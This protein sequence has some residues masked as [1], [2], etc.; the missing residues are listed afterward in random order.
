MSVSDKK[1]KVLFD[2]APF[3]IS[4]VDSEN[5]IIES[6]K[7]L[8]RILKITKEDLKEEI[9]RK[10]KYIDSAGKELLSE[11]FPSS[12]ALK[13]KKT[14]RDFEIGIIDDQERTI[15]TRVSAIPFI[16]DGDF[17]V[18][19]VRDI[20]EQKEAELALQES[21]ERYR[22]LM[23]NSGLG[24][25]YYDLSGKILMIN[26]IAVQNIGGKLS[27]YLGKNLI[28]V[29][30]IKTGQIFIER[31]KLSSKSAR[32]IQFEDRLKVHSNYKWYLSTYNRI[33]DKNGN[34]EGIQVTSADITGRKKNEIQIS[35]SQE[36][37]HKLTIH[38]EEIRESE[39]LQIAMNL[40]DDLG[41]KLTALNLNLA[42][43]KKRFGKQLP[44]IGEKI[45]EMGL[46]IQESIE[47]IREIS[48]Y[49]RPPL[50][51]DL[52][53]IPAFESLIKK[54]EK[55]SGIK[56]FFT[57][58]SDELKGNNKISV[59]LYRV[60]QESLTNIARHSGASN[61][62]VTLKTLK[63]NTELIISDDG[64]GIKTREIN[65]GKSLGIAGIKER[66]KSI[67]G[68]F[69]IKGVKDK[70]TSIKVSIPLKKTRKS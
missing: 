31:L 38:L 36:K 24:I 68:K 70:G 8:D 41:Q 53:I 52:G 37:L 9:F 34:V 51:Y 42:W 59:I 3:G 64:K 19:I 25:S 11:N 33:L 18:L 54:F 56:T 17:A 43:I 30:G 60:L 16:D 21:E 20:S 50:L 45:S 65:S 48:S 2:S 57:S 29:F 4:I 5:T 26:Q 13:E 39:M 6:N 69:Q 12:V 22:Q 55:Q 46:T 28:E 14:I 1:Y 10:R 32:P 47:G 62:R 44:S 7:S 35:Q 49:L 40:H 58:D 63:G 67:N 23:E 15:W 27:D 66:I 61:V